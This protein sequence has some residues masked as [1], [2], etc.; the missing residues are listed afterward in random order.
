MIT[1]IFGD[2]ITEGLWD[3]RG[4]WADRIKAYVQ[5]QELKS[6]FKNYH[7][8]YNLGIDGNTTDDILERFEGET[9]ARLWPDES[10]AFIFATG[11]NDTM[12]RGKQDFAS[13]PEQYHDQL[14]KIT[15]LAKRLTQKVAFVDLTPVDEALSNPIKSSA[16]GKCYTNERIQQFNRVLHELCQQQGVT[17]IE[18]NKLFAAQDYKPMLADGLHPNDAGHELI[19][20]KVLPVVQSWL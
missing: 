18:I 14:A 5:G 8:A 12:H 4:G 16:T 15:E 9:R 13:T 10:Y 17:L 20:T 3:S 2:S 7:Q 1:F 19:Y 11:I 6:G